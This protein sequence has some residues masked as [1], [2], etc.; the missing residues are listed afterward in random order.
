MRTIAM[1]LTLCFALLLLVGC[2]GPRR[3]TP[4]PPRIVSSDTPAEAE[5]RARVWRMKDAMDAQKA[6]RVT[7]PTPS[8]DAYVEAARLQAIGQALMGIGLGGGM[9]RMPPLQ[10]L[11]SIPAYQYQPIPISPRQLH[12]T[13][14]AI[15]AWL[16]QN[17][18]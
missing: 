4:E 15:G 12:C 6:T 14:N 8:E 7:T 16:Y 13:Y 17:C 18:S 3:K 10:P 9:F 1:T 11:P 2:S 5:Q